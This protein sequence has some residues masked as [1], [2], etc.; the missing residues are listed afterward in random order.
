MA[1]R[2]ATQAEANYII[3]LS[4]KVM[5]E[6]HLIQ[7]VSGIRAGKSKSFTLQEMKFYIV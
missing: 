5:K 3:Q 4:G 2:R 1:I 6:A 7:P